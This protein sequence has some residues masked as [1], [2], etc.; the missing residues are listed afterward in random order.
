MGLLPQNVVC[1]SEGLNEP[2]GSFS[3][4]CDV[5]N[6]KSLGFSFSLCGSGGY[7]LG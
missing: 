2:T 7:I 5:G 4:V 6:E 3:L 1:G